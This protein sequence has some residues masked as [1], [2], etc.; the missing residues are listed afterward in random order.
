[1][2]ERVRQEVQIHSRLK[3]PSIL[4]LYTFFEDES[5]VYLVL[6]LC[7]NGELGK[8]VR[9][10]GSLT[11]DEARGYVRQIVDGMLYLHSN[12]ILH[13]DLSLSN[14]LLDSRYRAKIAD[15]GLATQLSSPEERHKTMCGTPNYISPEVATRSWH[16]ME[17]DV[18]ALGC[19]LFTMLVGR[20]PF[21]TD[22]VRSTLTRV[23]MS[24]VRIPPT[25]SAEAAGLITG[26]LRKR[27]TERLPLT[28]VLQH[29][30]MTVGRAAPSA[31]GTRSWSAADSGVGSVLTTNTTSSAEQT[32]TRR[33]PRVHSLDR[34]LSRRQQDGAAREAALPP[35]GMAH[36]RRRFEPLPA[37][38]LAPM[39]PEEAAPR[40]RPSGRRPEQAAASH[41]SWCERPPQQ[42]E[43]SCRSASRS[44]RSTDQCRSNTGDV[45]Q[46]LQPP[47][48]ESRPPISPLN[49]RRLKPTRQR[50][51]NAVLTL[52]D[53]GEVCLEFVRR[54]QGRDAVVDVCRITSDGQRIVVYQPDGG[55]P[56]PVGTAPPPM[57]HSGADAF[58]SYQ[59][60]PSKHWKKYIYAARFVKLVKTKTPKLT[61]YTDRAKCVLM[62]NGP[63][64]D[65]VASFYDGCQVARLSEKVTLTEPGRKPYTLED[66]GG[67]PCLSET[68]RCIWEHYRQCLSHCQQLEAALERLQSATGTAAPFD[69]FPAIIG[70]R[71]SSSDG[72]S[73]PRHDQENR[74]PLTLQ[75]GAS[76]LGAMRSFDGSV[77]SG[78]TA[79]SAPAA[80]AGKA[81]R[82][83]HFPGV[84]TATQLPDGRLQVTCE[85]GTDLT[86]EPRSGAVQLRDTDGRLRHYGK[87]DALPSRIR[88]VMQ[89]L[90]HIVQ[91]IVGGDARPRHPLRD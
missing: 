4:E 78:R 66:V 56:V 69:C 14:L 27:P 15:F 34:G 20:P 42:E 70:R 36:L 9:S 8:Y 72:G 75:R 26:L 62:E 46:G 53:D 91:T 28:A 21:D 40:D 3:H 55:G 68:G 33:P 85:D 17:A 73:S 88:R 65:F 51:K 90:P 11:E 38:P 67:P 5:A 77:V 37:R 64:P 18:W 59:T 48:G 16:G 57:P 86:I 39:P 44:A 19:M 31:A 30:F 45:L 50:T 49:T 58:Y 12:K 83:A 22:G 25:V 61:L 13:R 80:A 29:P 2:V 41:R 71:P 43:C 74:S 60:L 32:R 24:D 82:R 87:H 76:Q 1:M 52:A 35:A 47:G 79:S 89:Q 84:G 10:K 23:V 7:T 63:V 81:A 6:E 54:R